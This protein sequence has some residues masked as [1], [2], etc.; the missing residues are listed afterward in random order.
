VEALEPRLR[1]IAEGVAIATG[2]TVRIE[3]QVG[4]RDFNINHTLNN[5][6]LEEFSA[7]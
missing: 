1:A 6:F 7:S 4:P 2:T 5:L 3:H